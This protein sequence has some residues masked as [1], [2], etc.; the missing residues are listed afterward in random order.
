MNVTEPIRRH[1]MVRPEAPAFVTSGGAVV[2]YAQFE[3]EIDAVARRAGS[4]GL[5]PG[6]CV[7]LAVADRYRQMVA[8]LGLARI[9][10]AHGPLQLPAHAVTAAL[11]DGSEHYPGSV[12]T[13]GLADV[14]SDAAT[15]PAPVEMYADGTAPY[16]YCATSGTTGAA[17]LVPI[18]HNISLRRARERMSAAS[19]MAHGRRP[20]TVRLASFVGPRTSYGFSGALLVLHGGGAV[21]HHP[22]GASEMRRW[23][24]RSGVNHL[25][26]SPVTLHKLLQALPGR[27]EN[28]LETIEVGGG[29]LSRTVY[30][31][32]CARL[33][34]NIWMGYGFTECGPVAAAPMQEVQARMGGVGYACPGVALRVVGENGEALPPGEEG[35]LGVRSES[36]AQ[37]YLDSPAA[38]AA[39]FRDGWVHPGDRAILEPDGYL[40][41]LGRA[42]DVINLGGVKILPQAIE[43][44]MLALGD[45]QEAAVFAVERGALPVL[46]AA[47]V[48]SATMNAEAY[49]QR[50]RARLGTRTPVVIMHL[51]ELPRNEMGKVRRADLAAAVLEHKKWGPRA[52]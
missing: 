33:C 22:S 45:V 39:V 28:T 6:Q 24:A 3:R 2:S 35:L 37:G 21:V 8:A 20:E 42:D 38:Q 41:I 1:A 40:R 7:V 25:I 34:A 44:V 30:D 4:L 15:D 29:A 14:W 49:H 50:C 52:P 13:I 16:M 17:K 19:A 9:G 43:E 26:A 47:V 46:C 10:V 11:L 18:S 5:A 51:A 23:F 31:E 12:R 27:I 36:S 48:P 32:V